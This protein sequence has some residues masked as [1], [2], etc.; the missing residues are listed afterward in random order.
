MEYILTKKVQEESLEALAKII[1]YPSVIDESA[2][3]TPFGQPIQDCLEGT[4]A[5][6]D[7]LGFKTY[8]DPEGYYGY[9]EVGEGEEL[10]AILCHLDVVPIGDENDWSYPPFEATIQDGKLYGRGSIDDKGPSVAALYAVKALMD[11]GAQFT[12]RVR[13]IFGTDEENLWRCMERY[14]QLEEKADYGFAPDSSFPLTFAEKGL[15]NVY[16]EGAGTDELVVHSDGAFNLVP[17]KAKYSG[18]NTHKLADAL[19]QLGYEYTVSGEEVTVFG[20]SVHS[21]DAHVGINAL[22]RLAEGLNAIYDHAPLKF[23]AKYFADGALVESLYGTVEDEVSGPLT[24]NFSKLIINEQETKIGLDIRVPVTEDDDQLMQKLADAAAEY[25]LEYHE[26]DHLESL[27]VP[28]ESDYIQTL[29]RIYQELTGDTQSEPI[30]SG[31][32]TF[33]RT[34]DNCVAYGALLPGYPATEHQVD[35]YIVLSNFYDAMEIYA[36]AIKELATK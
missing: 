13:F 19:D 20:K 8:I 32:A 3:T 21:K 9:A 22:A 28:K 15:V 34:M 24:L 35:E 25:G 30:S 5:I 31:G 10:F 4:L 23:L 26:F 2:E 1:S 14:N 11:E 18:A 17:D 29:L 27:Y 6:C 7:S 36:H 33:A 16:L 12:K